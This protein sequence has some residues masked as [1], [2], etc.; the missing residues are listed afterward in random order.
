MAIKPKKGNVGKSRKP[1][2][3][4]SYLFVTKD[5]IIDALR[6]GVSDSGYTYNQIHNASG[7]SLT[8]LN[9][10]FKGN[11]KRP[12]FAT[13]AAVTSAIGRHVIRFKAGKPV[14]E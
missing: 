2:T 4:K 3:Y 12:Q 10:W 11:V 6:T 13:V 14:L 9:G 5:P 8:T 7:V 1:A